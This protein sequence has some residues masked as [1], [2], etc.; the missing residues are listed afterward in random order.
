VVQLVVLVQKVAAVPAASCHFVV[1]M[2]VAVML[3]H[4]QLVPPALDGL[5]Q[6]WH[7]FVLLFL[8]N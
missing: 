2:L 8:G 7:E 3:F 6:L 4:A 1:E 5:H